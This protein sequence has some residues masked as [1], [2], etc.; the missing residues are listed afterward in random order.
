M[1]KG[2]FA[3]REMW[4]NSCGDAGGEVGG[5]GESSDIRNTY[6]LLFSERG[7]FIWTPSEGATVELCGTAG[8]VIREC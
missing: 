1:V 5:V 7:S 4:G 2:D 8:M 6:F 3:E